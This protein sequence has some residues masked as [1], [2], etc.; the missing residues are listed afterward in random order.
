VAGWW[1]GP[2][3]P[4]VVSAKF[5]LSDD[6]VAAVEE[7][8]GSGAVSNREIIVSAAGGTN[9]VNSMIQWGIIERDRVI[10]IAQI[11]GSKQADIEDMFDEPWYLDLVN[12]SGAASVNASKLCPGDRIVARIEAVTG[13]YDHYRPA[14]HL[15]REQET[16]LPQL[17]DDVLDRFETL[18]EQINSRLT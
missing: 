9:K 6:D 15:L 3:L 13:S 14:A 18:F 4:T 8:L 1:G 10:P 17:S 12:S 16:L 7:Q 11:I 2:E 5:D